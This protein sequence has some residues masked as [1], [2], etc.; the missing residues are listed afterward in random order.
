MKSKIFLYFL[1]VLLLIQ[2]L[3]ASEVYYFESFAESPKQIAYLFEND[4]VRF[5]EKN[6]EHILVLEEVREN[7][8]TLGFFIYKEKRASLTLRRDTSV[9]IDV[10]RDFKDDFK[11][12][13]RDF[14]FDLKKAVIRVETLPG[15]YSEIVDNE[16][17]KITGKITAVNEFQKQLIG[18]ALTVI[19]I[20]IGLLI[21]YYLFK[22]FR[23]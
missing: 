15:F 17:S 13:L 11:V 2:S 16:E 4:A 22:R 10:D 3:N 12:S 21:F 6:G 14:N 1:I 18:T 5:N 23:S 7:D 8:T 9:N 19:V 20:V